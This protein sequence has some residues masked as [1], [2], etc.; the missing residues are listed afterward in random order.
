MALNIIGYN[1]QNCSVE[2]GIAPTENY[3]K[4]NTEKIA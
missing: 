2:K 3:A 1:L 4:R